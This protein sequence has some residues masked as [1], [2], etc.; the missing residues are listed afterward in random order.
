MRKWQRILFIILLVGVC[1]P[2]GD[3]LALPSYTAGNTIEFDYVGGQRQVGFQPAQ[4]GSASGGASDPI[5]GNWQTVYV[6]AHTTVS[7]ISPGVWSLSTDP[8]ILILSP[9]SSDY[10][11]PSQYL[12][13]AQATAQTIDFNTGTVTW[14]AV[15]ILGVNNFI[16]SSTLQQ[17]S[18]YS[19]GTLTMSFATDAALQ[20][21]AQTP[22][23]TLTSSYSST[24]TG[25]PEPHVWMLWLTGLGLLG[26]T[27]YRRHAVPAS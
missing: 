26:Y 15:S 21:W 17:F 16:S 3:A 14:G 24:L 4:V 9:S 2:P 6:P 10:N 11:T 7:Q 27:R 12:I 25:T 22:S 8:E 1:P 13:Q 23:G 19:T 20:S 18:G 5:I